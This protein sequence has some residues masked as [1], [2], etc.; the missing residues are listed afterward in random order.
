[1]RLGYLTVPFLDRPLEAAL[2]LAVDLGLDTVEIPAGGFFSTNHLDPI[3]LAEDPDGVAR[4]GGAVREHGLEISAMALHGNPVH[5]EEGRRVAYRAQFEAACRVAEQL[6]VRR[7]TLLAGLPGAGPGA[8]YPNWITFP[9]PEE[10]ESG[11]AWQ[12]EEALV[13]HWQVAARRAA[14]HGVTLCFEMVPGDCVHNPRTFLRLRD[15]LDVEVRCNLDPSHFFHQG[16]DPVAAVHRLAGTIGHV[17]AKDAFIHR[18]VARVDG[19][20]DTAPLGAVEARGWS[21]RTLGWGHDEG[22]WR[23]FLGALRMAGYDDVVSIEHEDVLLAREEG[24]RQ[25]AGLLQRMLPSQP[26]EKAWWDGDH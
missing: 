4:L 23:G 24:I 11:L 7:F 14:D 21:Y 2:D 3:A 1:V 10:L 16:I 22:F 6:G 20:L 9:F 8:R 18:E 26:R 13:P 25:A 19:L 17:H 15:A 12:W 5:P